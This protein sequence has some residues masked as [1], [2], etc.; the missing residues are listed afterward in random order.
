MIII[1]ILYLVSCKLGDKQERKKKGKKPKKP[2]T[3]PW[4]GQP[5]FLQCDG[6]PYYPDEDSKKPYYWRPARDSPVDFVSWFS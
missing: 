6:Q 1:S 3:S 4:A 5:L 2:T